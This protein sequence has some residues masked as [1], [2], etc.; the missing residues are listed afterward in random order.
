MQRVPC[1]RHAPFTHV[2]ETPV[3]SHLLTGARSEKPASAA[4]GIAD[5]VHRGLTFWQSICDK[6]K[7][8]HVL[9]WIAYGYRL[10]WEG[11][12]PASFPHVANQPSAFAHAEFVDQ[13]V[14]EMLTAAAVRKTCTRPRCVSPLGVVPKANNKLRLILDTRG[15]NSH[16][17]K[18][19]FRMES[20]LDLRDTAQRGDWLIS[21]DQTQGYYHVD[22]H[23]T[24]QEYMG[25]EWR[26]QFYTFCVLPFGLSTAPRVFSKIM[27]CLVRHWRS[28]GTRM[29]A[30][31]DDWLFSCCSPADCAALLERLRRDCERAHIRINWPKSQT[32][33]TQQLR[34]L[35]FLV[36]TRA[37]VFGITADRWA[38]LQAGLELLAAGNS[39]QARLVARVTGQAI[40]M[41]LAMGD[42]ARLFTRNLYDA[43]DTRVSWQGRVALSEDCQADIA[44]W[45]GLPRQALTQPIWG[46]QDDAPAVLL[47]CDASGIGWGGL[48]MGDTAATPGPTAQ[49]YFL[50]WER[51]ESSTHRELRGLLLTLQSLLHVCHGKR[52]RVQVDNYNLLYI[53]GR[54]AHSPGLN[55]LAREL[56]WF[57]L[58]NHIRLEVVW[59]P[60]D[61]NQAADA[62]SKF[63]D[64]EDW[65]VNP[66]LFAWL[67]RRFGP[68]AVDRFATHLNHLCS[69]FFSRHWCPGTAG[70]DSF[71]FSWFL[72]VGWINPPFSLVGRVIRKL[73]RE[74]AV[75]TVIVPVW[76]GRAWWPLIA[77]DGTHLDSHVVDWTWLPRQTDTFLPGVSSG[78]QSARDAPRWRILAIRFDFSTDTP[79]LCKAERCISEGCSN[80]G[81][82]SRPSSWHRDPSASARCAGRGL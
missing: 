68:H 28:Q 79:H 81:A 4:A 43:I 59:V 36:D 12:P 77:P 54:G 24:A 64:T 20:L 34:H 51:V 38:K 5:R 56:F 45:R 42:V 37:G 53:V 30:Y 55:K 13:Q 2:P 78:N 66:E 1:S 46:V 61:L 27:G 40:Y 35:G 57:C 76:R 60:R 17:R 39:V 15:V 50:P 22:L 70:V 6:V 10:E 82:H 63:E 69:R 33:P 21:L 23:A 14:D 65:Q 52:V 8:A 9:D 3:A 31:L 71:A 62:L 25:F 26:G 80:C 7:D 16:L 58:A 75:A 18:V 41:S 32:T 44:F 73:Q 47:A 67:E 19:S 29:L 49:G 11:E 74:R 72:E 48:Q